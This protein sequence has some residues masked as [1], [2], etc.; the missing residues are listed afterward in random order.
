MGLLSD[1]EPDDSR[2]WKWAGVAIEFPVAVALFS[3]FGYLFDQRYATSPWG[4]LS[5]GAFGFV[6][7]MYLL[8]R[9]AYA[10]MRD[11]DDSPKS[12]QDPPGKGPEPPA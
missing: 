7:G 5:G 1:Q 12:G 9:S 6:S 2:Y 3:F 10:M 4:L 8:I 11:L